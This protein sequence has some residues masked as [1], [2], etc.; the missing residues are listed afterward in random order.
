V[1]E[2]NDEPNL[3]L[4]T[5]QLFTELTD[6]LQNLHQNKIIH[7][8]IKLSNVFINNNQIILNDFGTAV[9][10]SKTPIQF[11]G[12]L[13]HAPQEILQILSKDGNNTY[14]PK[15]ADDLVML[16]K[17][18]FQALCPATFE[19]IRTETNPQTILKFWE[20]I[21]QIKAWS[22]LMKLALKSDYATL[23]LRFV[24]LFPSKQWDKREVEEFNS[25]STSTEDV[26]ESESP[27][28]IVGVALQSRIIS[29]L[30]DRKRVTLNGLW[31]HLSTNLGGVNNLVKFYPDETALERALELIEEIN[32]DENSVYSL[33]NDGQ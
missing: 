2:L 24:V 23:K 18:A 9:V 31:S 27:E 13:R 15:P 3:A 30:Q 12:A 14:I 25:K 26:S 22:E 17:M 8:D 32:L 16:V 29:I 6:I 5:L 1:A 20:Y 19:V 28:E 33:K 4:P 7:R 10:Q 11:S 21:L